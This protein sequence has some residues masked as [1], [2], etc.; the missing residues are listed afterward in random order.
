MARIMEMSNRWIVKIRVE[1][2]DAN[3]DKEFVKNNG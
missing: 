2:D 1:K 3:E